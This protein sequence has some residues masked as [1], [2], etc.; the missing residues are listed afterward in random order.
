MR[1][2]VCLCARAQIQ[3]GKQRG[4]GMEGGKKRKRKGGRKRVR[5]RRIG[6]VIVTLHPTT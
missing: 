1:A 5:R 4:M 3:A 2:R 6:R